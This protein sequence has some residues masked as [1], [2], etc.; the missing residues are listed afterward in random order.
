MG[1]SVNVQRSGELNNKIT[2]GLKFGLLNSWHTEVLLLVSSC[3]YS[4]L[5][6]ARELVKGLLELRHTIH[7]MEFQMSLKRFSVGPA[8]CHAVACI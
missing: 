2:S 6:V 8:L 5:G 7:S 3:V 1:F 4:F